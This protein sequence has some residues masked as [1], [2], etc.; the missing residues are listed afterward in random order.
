MGDEVRLVLCNVP[1]GESEELAK[2]LIERRLAACVNIVPGV[3][4]VYRWEGKVCVD[5]EST[6]LIKTTVARMVD[7]T[8]A[9][10]ELHSYSLPEVIS[11]PLDQEMGELRYLDWVRSEL[12]G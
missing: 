8:A 3:K 12:G 4:S 2:A 7:L 5:S 11:V 9:I 10:N 1:P 6:L